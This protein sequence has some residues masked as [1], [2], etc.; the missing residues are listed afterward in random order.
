MKRQEEETTIG[1]SER[2]WVVHHKLRLVAWNDPI[3]PPAMTFPCIIVQHLNARFV[4][5]SF[6]QSLPS[7]LVNISAARFLAKK[8]DLRLL[9]SNMAGYKTFVAISRRIQE[10]LVN[11]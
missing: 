6:L 1:R 3:N 2:P 7:Q 9:E 8:A 11:R 5:K 4:A 10:V